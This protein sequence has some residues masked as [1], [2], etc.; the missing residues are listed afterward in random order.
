MTI[1]GLLQLG[2][3]CLLSFP[4]AAARAASPI[5]PLPPSERLS[6]REALTTTLAQHPEIRISQ[7]QV[8]Y[9][10]GATQRARGQFDVNLSAGINQRG[11]TTPISPLYQMFYG[12]PSSISTAT[13]NYFLDASTQ[14]R[15]GMMASASIQMNRIA[16]NIAPFPYT[17][18]LPYAQS[19]LTFSIVQPLLR[20][21]GAESTAADERAALL[22][23]EASRHELR[24]VIA[25][26]LRDTCAAYF[27][28][29]AA[30]S[31][32][33]RWVEAEDRAEKLQADE[34][35]LVEAGQHPASSLK[36]LAAN[37]A[38]VRAAR[39]DSERQLQVAR[40]T[41]LLTMGL[42]WQ[43]QGRV[44]PP[45]DKYAPPS[46]DSFPKDED[47]DALVRM[48]FERRADLLAAQAVLAASR[49]QTRAAKR[50]LEPRL[51]AQV[52]LG[53]SGLAEGS[54]A[55][56][57]FTA[58]YSNISGV[59][60]LAGLSLQLPVQ[61]NVAR[62]ALAQRQSQEAQAQLQLENLKRQIGAQVALLV[63]SVRLAAQALRSAEG[64]VDAYQG[65]L[66]DERKKVRVG[67]ST[68]FDLV[69][70]Q[71]RLNAA[72][73]NAVF[74]RAR[75]ATLITQARFETGTLLTRDGEQVSINLEE[76]GSFPSAAISRATPS[77]R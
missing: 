73:Q 37:L 7:Q 57:F 66:E 40:Q 47:L 19:V 59:N 70:V 15:F 28:Y 77:T 46:E 51:D 25:E 41:L 20:G 22:Q 24:Q 58:P 38:E 69:Q 27:G 4:F 43:E 29:V 39:A 5:S 21:R 3:L 31:S 48:T 55:A 2:I 71:S 8:L 64:A 30:S 11:D 6:L 13:T 34:Q 16:Q 52:D 35:R 12:G 65:A 42:S 1:S 32:V 9:S 23:E 60:F 76:L 36:L 49:V 45:E 10:H 75:L 53:Y 44:A 54:G 50:W 14:F 63:S 61:N 26:H 67:L 68:V 62:G 56:P 18:Q 72:V 17:S 33:A 74:S